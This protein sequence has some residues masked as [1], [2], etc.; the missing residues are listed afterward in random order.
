M[1][2]FHIIIFNQNIDGSQLTMIRLTTLQSISEKILTRSN[3]CLSG[4]ILFLGY[5]I[6]VLTY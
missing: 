2:H 4:F 6:W 3:Y 5:I 1:N